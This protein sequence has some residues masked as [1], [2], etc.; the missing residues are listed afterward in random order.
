MRADALRLAE[1]ATVGALMLSPRAIDSV[2]RWLRRSDFA[3]P[4]LGEVFTVLL[5]QHRDGGPCD[6]RSLGSVLASTRPP[7]SARLPRLLDVLQATPTN[8][9]PAAYARVVAES[10]LRREVVG[11]GVVL[12]AGALAA[13]RQQAASPLLSTVEQLHVLLDDAD[14]RWGLAQ[15]NSPSATNA[16]APAVIPD[17][18][19]L[20]L[21]ADRYLSAHS[22]D[23]EQ[24]AAL[25][26]QQFA[27]ALVV[28]PAAAA[29]AAQVLQ[30]EWLVDPDWAA[31]FAA[32]LDLRARH[33]PVDPV[34]VAWE[35]N[36]AS[37]LRG[38][39]PQPQVLLAAV[40]SAL[41]VDP[42]RAAALVSADLT[43]RTAAAATQS[44]QVAADNPGVTVPDLV[45]TARVWMAATLAASRGLSAHVADRAPMGVEHV[46]ARGRTVA[47]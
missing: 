17:T 6:P 15:S 30:P 1:E 9:H 19:A 33:E 11:L 16:P 47:G 20:R 36:R 14:R 3:D 38:P 34:T 37:R 26:E 2:S 5:E 42:L 28:R 8:P 31:V 21:G 46:V 35:L 39:G 7:H 44:L 27:A 32:V 12:R 4:W 22:G 13:A 43:Q 45:H 18:E 40:E 29:R 24:E 41:T 23:N 10:G 25:R